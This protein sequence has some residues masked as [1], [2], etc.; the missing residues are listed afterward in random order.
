MNRSENERRRRVLLDDY[1]FQPN[2]LSALNSICSE[3]GQLY[4]EEDLL[5]RVGRWNNTSNPETEGVKRHNQSDQCRYCTESL[6][7]GKAESS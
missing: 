6:V 3:L 1:L 5:R 4:L 7:G 2:N